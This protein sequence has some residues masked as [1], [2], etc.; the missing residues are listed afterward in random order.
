MAYRSSRTDLSERDY[1]H[2]RAPVREYDDDISDRVD[3]TPAFLRE[4][5]RR[6]DV[7]P[8]VLRAREV[9]TVDRR[10]ARTPSPQVRYRERFVEREVDRPPVR[11]V[12]RSPSPPPRVQVIER[13]ERRERERSPTPDRERELIRLRI[14]RER[15]KERT[16][17]PSPSPPPPQPQVIRGPTIEREVITHWRDIDH[18]M[19]R[20]KP[21]TPPPA[22][23]RVPS[24]APSRARERE[25]DIDIDIS[26]N[27]T[28]IDIRQRT[29]SRSRPRSQSRPRERPR[30]LTRPSYDDDD[31][32]IVRNRDKLKVTDTPR[33]RAHS[34][35]PRP[36]WDDEAEYITSKIDSRGRMGEAYHGATKDWTIVDVP[37]GTERVKMDG[38]G[39]GGAEVTWQRYNGVRRSKFIPEREDSPSS[40]LVP[41]PV[42]SE[43]PRESSRE[44]LSVQIYDSKRRDRELEVEEVRDRRISIRDGDRHQTRKRD[45]MWTE[46]TKDLVNRE[47]IDRLG[48]DYEETE[49]FFYVMQY[50]RYEDVLELVD[51]TEDIRR[52]RKRRSTREYEEDRYGYHRRHHHRH[53]PWDKADD[54]RI[55]EREVIY[56]SAPPRFYR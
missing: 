23:R 12:E 2:R 54:E 22:P 35:A 33:R 46:I 56:D 49:W 9:E 3:R 48:Y 39:G 19:V 28:D 13:V 5:V 4:E 10:R 21:P 14:E 32:V 17:S 15:Q 8:L 44:R 42:L 30:P 18:G 51:L 43:P 38:V 27:E 55:V 50:L 11:F 52:A 7:G 45:G 53:T 1:A 41:A 47:A 37:P 31:L 29:R 24:R 40:S 20:A 34:A 26:R 6:A 16:P 25:T 36:E